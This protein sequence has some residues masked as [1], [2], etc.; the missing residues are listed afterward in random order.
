[1]IAD[2]VEAWAY[3]F[4]QADAM[5]TDEIQQRFNCPAFTEAAQVLDMT[6]RPQQHRSQ[7]EQRLKAQRDER[8]RMQYAVDQARLEGEALG[9]AR[10]EARGRISIL[11]KILG[12]EPESLDSLSLEQLTVIEKELQNQ[13]RERGI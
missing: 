10:A 12:G 8:A 9:E 11:R 3:F 7:Y 4:R 5:T 1:M 6:Q 13:L 2:P